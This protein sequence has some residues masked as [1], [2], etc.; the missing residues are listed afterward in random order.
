MKEAF[1][2]LGRN[3][4]AKDLFV[5]SACALGLWTGAAYALAQ[6]GVPE[7]EVKAGVAFAMAGLSAAAALAFTAATFGILVTKAIF[8][9][10]RSENWAK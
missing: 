6:A 4:T 2:R 7:S 3:T 8:R 5:T 10:G 1:R 9:K